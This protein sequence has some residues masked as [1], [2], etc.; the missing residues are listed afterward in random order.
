VISL[1]PK[2]VA[3]SLGMNPNGVLDYLSD[4]VDDDR[5]ASSNL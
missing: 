5:L 2:L 3:E 1:D 4:H